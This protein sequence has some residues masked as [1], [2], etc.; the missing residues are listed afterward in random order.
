M[1]TPSPSPLASLSPPSTRERLARCTAPDALPLPPPL[2]MPPLVDRRDD[3][4][5]TEMPPRKREVGYGIRDTLVDLTEIVPEIAPMTVREVN[6]KR[7]DLLMEDKIAHQ[8]T[9]HIM[10]DEA[11][12]VREA[13]AHSIGLSQAVHSKLQTHQEQVQIMEPVTRQGPSTLPNNTNPNNMTLESVQAMIDQ[14][15]LRNSTNGDRSHS[16]VGL[17]RWIEKLESV[18][19]I[20]GCTV[21]NQV[22]FT[23]YTLLDGALTCWNSQIRSLGPDEY[24]MTW[25]FV[26]DETE[27]IDKYVSELPD[28]IYNSVKAS[29]PKT[30]DET[31]ELA[32]DLMD[33]KLPTFAERQTNNKRKD[34]DSFKNN[35][36]HQQQIPK[37]QNVARLSS[38]AH[39]SLVTWPA[40]RPSLGESLPSVP[41]AYAVAMSSVSGAETRV[42]TPVPVSGISSLRSTSGGMSRG[43]GSGNASGVVHLARHSLVEGGDSEASGDGDGVGMARSLSVGILDLMRQSTGLANESSAKKKGK[44]V[45]LTTEDKQKRRNDVK[46]RTTLLLALHNEHQLRFSK[47][48]TAQELWGAILKTFGGNEATKKTKKNQLK[49]QYGNFK[50]EGRKGEVNTASIP[51]AI[52]QV[53]P[54]SADVA[55]ASISHDTVCAYIA[56]QS[57]GSQ[58]KYEDINQIDEDDIEEMDIKECRAPMSQDRGRREIYKQGSKEEEKAPKDLMAIDRV[59]WD[60]SYMANK[61]KNHALVAD[62]EALT[63]FTLMANSSSS[64]KNEDTLL[65]PPPAQVYSPPKKDMSWTGLPEFADDTIT[66]YSR[67]SPSIESN[68]SDLQ[69]S[70]SSVFE[71]GESSESIMYKP[72]IKFVKAVDCADVKTNKVVAARK[73][74]VKYAKMYRITSKSPKGNSQNIID[75]RGYWDSGCSWHM[76]GNISYLSDYEPYDRGYASADE[77]MLWHMRL[78]HLN[79]KTM[80]KLVRNNLVKGLPSKCFEN[81]HTCVACLKGKQHK[82]SCKTKLVNS[83]SKPLHTLH[84]DLFGP[85][86]ISSLNHTWYCLVVTDDFLEMNE[87]CTRKGIKREFSNAR[88]PQQNGVAE[89]RN[90]SLIEAARTM[91]A[92][93]K[94]PVT[95]WAEAVNIAC[96]K[97]AVSQ[98]VKKDVASLRYI[99]LP[100]WF[101]EAHLES[102][103]SNAQDACNVDAPESNGNSNPTATLTNPPADQME[104]LTVKSAIPTVSSHV[105]IA[106]LDDS[107]EPSSTTRLISKR[108]TSQDETPSL[109]NILT[110]SNRFEDILEVTTNTSDTNGVE[111]DLGNMECNISASPTPT[112]RIH[113]DHPEIQ[114]ISPVDT[115]IQTR[116]KSKKMEEQSFI[117]TIHQKTTPGL[118]QFCLFSCFLSQ[119]EPKKIP[120]ALKDPSYVLKNKKDERGIVIRNKARL[121]AQGHTQEEEIDYEEVFA[122]VAMIEAIRLF[123]AYASF[124]GFTVYKMDVKSEFLYG[125]IDKEVYVMQLFRFQD[126]EFPDRVY[127]VE[128]AMYGLHQA[129]RAWYGTLSKYLLTNGFQRVLQKK[130]GIFLSQDKYVGDI[131]KKFRYSD[132]RSANTLMEKENPWGKDGPGKDV[133]L[134]L[135]RSMIGSLM[136]LTASRP[137]IMFVVCACARHQ[138]IVTTFTTEAEYVAAASGC[139][140]VLWIQNQMLDYGHHFIRDCFEKKLISVDYIHTDDNV[141]DLLTK[142]FDAGRFQYLVEGTRAHEVSMGMNL[143]QWRDGFGAMVQMVLE[144]NLPVTRP[145]LTSRAVSKSKSPIRRHLPRRPSSKTSNSPPRVT[146]AKAPVVSAAQGKKGTWVWR[147]KCPIIDHDLRNTSASMTFKRFDYNDALGRSKY[148][149][150]NMSYLYDFKDLN[151]GYVAFGG[152]PKRG[153]IT[154]KG[155]IKT[156]KL[157]FDDVYF[158]EEL[159]FNLFSV[160]QMCDKKNSVLFTDTGCLVLSFDFKLPDASQVLLR[161]PRENNMYNG[162]LKNIVPYG[163]LTCLFAKAILD[164]SNLWHR[165]LGHVNFK[166]INKLVKGNLVRGL[167][168]KVFANDNSCVTCKKDKQHRASCKSKPV[169][170]VDQPLFR[171]HMDLFGPT[172]VKSLS[173]KSYYL[174]ITDDYSRFSWV[175]FLASKDETTPVLKTFITGLENLLSL[176]VKVIRCDNGTEFK[177]SDLNQ[178][179]GLKGIK[180]EFSV[181]RTHH[182]AFRVFNSKTCIVQETLH[183][184]F[185]ENKPNVAGFQDIEKA[186]EEVAHTY[187]LFPVWSDGS[188]NP[189]NKDKDALVDGNEHD[190]NIQKSVSPDSKFEEC[191]NNSSNG[192]NAVGSLVYTVGHNFINSTNDFSVVGPSNTTASPTYANSSLQDTSTSS[193]NSDMPNLE[194]FT[195]SDDADDVG[196]EADI[197]NL[198]SVI[199]RAIG[200][201]WVYRNKKDERGIVIRN[202]ARLVAQGHTQEE[203][204]DSEEVFAPVARIEAIRLF[205]AY[206]SFMGFLVYQIDVKSA[207]LYGTI[208]EE[209][210]MCQPPG[211]EDPDHPDKVYKVVKAL[212][213]LYQAPRAWYETLDTYLLENGFQRG[214][215]DQTLFIKKQQKDILLVQI[216]V[217]DIIFGAT[218][219][220]LCK[221]F[222]KLMKDRFQMSSMGELTFFL[223]LQVKQKKD[224]IFISQDKYVAEIL[225][226]FGLTEGKS[227][228]TPIDAEKPLLKDSNGEDVDV[229]T[230]RSMIGSL[231][232]LTSSR[233]DIMFA[234]S[235]FDL[236]AYSDSD[237]AGASLDR[238][239]TTGGCQFLGCRLISWQCKKQIVVATSSIE[240]EY[241]AAASGCTQVLWIQNQL[242]DYGNMVI[243]IVVL[244]I[245][246]DVLLITT[247]G[248]QLIMSN[249]QERVDSP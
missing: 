91:L 25:E 12:A 136:Y 6:T 102:S 28:N 179:C 50:T 168:T 159:K 172:F 150:G 241:V 125:T 115:P 186:G 180:R 85:T 122:A 18:F 239:S 191:S 246:S 137:D 38:T 49:Q 195:H 35:H 110:L 42:H 67:P 249:P 126:L 220:A 247:N 113:K 208:D 121:V 210:Y 155:K 27:K 131:L 111:A 138:T 84:M 5:E 178:F 228:S 116:H 68:F 2:L 199:P 40:C 216:Y 8:E 248:V 143:V 218:N 127:K 201:K 44:T 74:F 174:V 181:P 97:D 107:L 123:L 177:N 173:K 214:T 238:K 56:S 15:L 104:T 205:L 233:P 225:R 94:L 245:L 165:R 101:H 76:T 157:D 72:M 232:Y 142:P 43:G 230:Y 98:D 82:A 184:N 182:K 158:V 206:A 215:I 80:N 78:G 128:K 86:S 100:N 17:T 235:P 148:M 22:K 47:Y 139:G 45:A 83:V 171:L 212:Y 229:H 154:G 57:N 156:G 190:E 103:T 140:Q 167:P 1:P 21:E 242:L 219:K 224:G 66:D 52:T 87:F 164:E 243:E 120:D 60:W 226:K 59:G 183:V 90:R 65:F 200:T 135:Y 62:D 33:Q 176:K 244:Y 194:D 92:D 236:V 153:K 19:Q 93:A 14:A 89:R 161:V 145:K 118:L 211:F 48:K 169:S 106:C 108:V 73:P 46:A 77:S 187:V 166:T 64:S 81:D 213:G 192:V 163:D 144:P 34:D 132:V 231:M 31:I 130:D 146:A 99:A 112:F 39:A 151:G 11:Y 188:T 133:E 96:T 223:G 209:V 170:S 109:D 26:A 75:D 51:T 41:D 53:S 29:K 32:K 134:Y 162:N 197:N 222:K 54:V 58:I 9:I 221:S 79:F 114:I 129:P 119:E 71:H 3:I 160:S 217:D 70:N 4:P 13:W 69:N 149:T 152:I 189:Q 10:D 16:M 198:E 196:A 55:V 20:S 185:M 37:R 7:I 175:F 237:Y 147:P 227:A 24:S 36:G 61:E 124:M 207:F 204:I 95:F 30:L 234:D 240:A 105:P 117:A 203:G 63:E 141:V 202:K 23:T 88:T 193:H